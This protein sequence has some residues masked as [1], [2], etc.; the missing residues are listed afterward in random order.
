MLQRRDFPCKNKRLYGNAVTST[1]TARTSRPR[2]KQRIIFQVTAFLLAICLCYKKN[3]N[4]GGRRHAHRGHQVCAA[5]NDLASAPFCGIVLTI[6]FNHCSCV[7]TQNVPPKQN[8]AGPSTEVFVEEEEEP[9]RKHPEVMTFDP[10]PLAERQQIEKAQDDPL[11]QTM[12]FSEEEIKLLSKASEKLSRF[13]VKNIHKPW[14]SRH[15]RM[16]GKDRVV[17]VLKESVS[18]LHNQRRKSRPGRV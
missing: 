17:A 7:G 14:L 6:S 8:D 13:S 15:C 18:N 3:G 12:G 4:P 2:M 1:T 10:K 11:V 16:L 9:Q 5:S